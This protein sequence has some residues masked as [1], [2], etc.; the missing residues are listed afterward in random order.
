MYYHMKDIVKNFS[1]YIPVCECFTDDIYV[2]CD[3]PHEI[4]LEFLHAIH[5]K[6]ECIKKRTTKSAS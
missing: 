3:C 5:T 1:C 2:I 4:F 6:D